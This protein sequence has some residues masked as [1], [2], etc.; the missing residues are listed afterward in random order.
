MS[1]SADHRCPALAGIARR[2]RPRLQM[3]TIDSAMLT[4]DGG[5]EG[6]CRGGPGPRQVTVI[7]EES[8]HDAIA[9]LEADLSWTLRRAN[10]LVRGIRLKDS[11]G[12]KLRIGDAMIEITEDNPPCRVM[13]IQ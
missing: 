7:V 12:S 5:V 13:D 2:A 3:E 10:L 8:W 1:A 6:D 9:E 11:V 4:L